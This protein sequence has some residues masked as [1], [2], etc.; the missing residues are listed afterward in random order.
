MRVFNRRRP[1]SP[2]LNLNAVLVHARREDVDHYPVDKLRDLPDDELVTYYGEPW[3]VGNLRDYL[4]GDPTDAAVDAELNLRREHAAQQTRR[5]SFYPRRSPGDQLADFLLETIHDQERYVAHYSWD[6][7]GLVPSHK[8][9]LHAERLLVHHYAVAKAAVDNHENG[10]P[11]HANL[12]GLTLALALAV[13]SHPRAP[14]HPAVA[15]HIT[16]ILEASR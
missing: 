2:P 12:P 10:T 15:Q 13:Q 4:A 3:R 14:G 16:T 9:R 1:V 7:D 6:H 5:E 8:E 11:E